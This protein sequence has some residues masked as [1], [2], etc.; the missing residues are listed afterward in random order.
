V[1]Y[2]KC[3]TCT[4]SIGAISYITHS[5]GLGGDT[6]V[7]DCS[8]IAGCLTCQ[9]SSDLSKIVCTAPM[10]GYECTP[11]VCKEKGACTR[12]NFFDANANTCVPCP[13][14]CV[15]CDKNDLDVLYCLYCGPGYQTVSQ[16]IQCKRKQNLTDPDCDP[17]QG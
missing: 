12:G 13:G 5:S 7:I 2:S 9:P 11:S 6:C 4:A 3:A 10:D 15:A 14:T 1:G 8:S 17:S 16:S